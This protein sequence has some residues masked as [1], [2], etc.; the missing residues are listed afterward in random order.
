MGMFSSLE[1]LRWIMWS[2]SSQFCSF[3]LASNC[4]PLHDSLYSSRPGFLAIPL[5][6]P[7][8]THTAWSVTFCV[9]LFMMTCYPSEYASASG[10]CHEHLAPSV[11]VY[12]QRASHRV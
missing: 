1:R 7:G 12:L 9:C 6:L 5:P 4:Y 3:R 11:F 2:T 10:F 8:G